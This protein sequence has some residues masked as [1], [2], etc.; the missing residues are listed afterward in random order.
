MA[1]ITVTAAMTDDELEQLFKD[2]SG[3]SRAAALRAVYKAGYDAGEIS[4]TKR[5]TAPDLEAY[6]VYKPKGAPSIMSESPPDVPVEDPPPDDEPSE[7][8][9]NP[10]ARHHKATKSH[11]LV[12]K[13]K[14]R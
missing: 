5:L 11:R 6:E 13:S 7:P 4:A 8:P 3:A 1:A 2:M 12:G 9:V 14:R 10:S